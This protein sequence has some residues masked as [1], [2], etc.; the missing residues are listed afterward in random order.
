MEVS[1]PSPNGWTVTILLPR[2][3][4]DIR[5]IRMP[6]SKRPHRGAHQPF[7][8]ARPGPA[9][10]LREAPSS[11]NP[12]P[13]AHVSPGPHLTWTMS[14]AHDRIEFT[15]RRYMEYT[16]MDGDQLDALMAVLPKLLE[17]L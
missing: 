17:G 15:S 10:P 5:D 7:P 13:C 8:C 12:S 14:P 4:S 3:E 2:S 9:L 6:P 16:G 11:R 1:H